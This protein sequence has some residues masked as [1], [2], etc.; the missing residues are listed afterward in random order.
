MEAL[1]RKHGKL[2]ESVVKQISGSGG[3]H[4]FFK[5]PTD[6]I[7][8]CSVSLIAPGIDVRGVGGYIIVEPSLHPQTHELY[9]F[10]NLGNQELTDCPD[11]LLDLA[12]PL[13][14][15][16][17][18][19][20]EAGRKATTCNNIADEVI[21]NGQRND[22]L[23]RHASK[24]RGSGMTEN[25]VFRAIS[26]FLP[27]QLQSFRIVFATVATLPNYSGSISNIASLSHR[28]MFERP[29]TYPLLFSQSLNSDSTNPLNSLPVSNSRIFTLFRTSLWI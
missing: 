6:R 25:E 7:V 21:I 26:T 29:S 2:E 4:Y 10:V 22:K 1:Q 11:W 12:A 17:T 18:E 24:L 8:N 20:V 13:E 28:L 9:Q 14:N 27:R 23:F 19:E 3:P 16:R 15:P 5:V